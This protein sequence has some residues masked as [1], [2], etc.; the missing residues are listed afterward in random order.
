[1]NSVFPS[2]LP[3]QVRALAARLG[4]RDGSPR[5]ARF[6]QAG[7]LRNLGHKRWTRFTATQSIESA[8]CSFT[9]R[10]RVAPM[11]A[12]RVE[13]ALM[14][15][16]PRGRV[17]LAGLIPLQQAQPGAEL[18]RGQLMRY[19]AELPWCPDAILANSALRWA[20][21]NSSKLSVGV[22]TV[23]AQ[24]EVTF[25]LDADGLPARVTG[26]R[27]SRVGDGYIELPWSGEFG[28]YRRIDGR[29]IPHRAEVAWTVDG[30]S[31]AVWLGELSR[32]TLR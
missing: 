26:L 10:A 28:R 3:D 9:W 21:V 27:P 25:E 12:V 29:L 5:I 6:Q 8:E 32:W 1:M 17:S 7:H 24:G 23:S 22:A 31:F 13:D 19:L 16:V 11:G 18:L 30:Q 14:N 15:G 4:A 20:V 2:D